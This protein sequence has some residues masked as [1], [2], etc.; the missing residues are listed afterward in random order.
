MDNPERYDECFTEYDPRVWID[1]G[2][3]VI[4][5][6]EV[7]AS[8]YKLLDEYL[9]QMYHEKVVVSVIDFIVWAY[10]LLSDTPKGEVYRQKVM[11]AINLALYKQRHQN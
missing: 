4:S 10:E 2:H 11:D 6:G 9:E 5:R 1:N 3:P 8:V 7:N